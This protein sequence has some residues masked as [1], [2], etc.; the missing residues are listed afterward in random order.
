[1]S[2][3]REYLSFFELYSRGDALPDEIDDFID[4]WHTSMAKR[5]PHEVSPLNQYLGLTKEE[6]DV[7]VQDSGALPLILIARNEN[8]PLWQVMEECVDNYVAAR[9]ANPSSLVALRNWL[10]KRKKA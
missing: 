10:A 3:S 2:D 1:M 8:R 4:S 9:A 6:Y 5:L 7:W